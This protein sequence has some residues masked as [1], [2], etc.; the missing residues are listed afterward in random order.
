MCPGWV[1]LLS[2]RRHDLDDY[3]AA[4]LSL[5]LVS[6]PPPSFSKLGRF[7]RDE[8][9]AMQ[10]RLWL[11]GPSCL[12]IEIGG[13]CKTSRGTQRKANCEMQQQGAMIG[14]ACLCRTS[15]TCSSPCCGCWG[16]TGTREDSQS[17]RTGHQ[18]CL[19]DD[20]DNKCNTFILRLPGIHCGAD[21]ALRCKVEM[22]GLHALH[23]ELP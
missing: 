18:D 8:W 12:G 21:E 3:V 1:S 16:I 6:I 15:S 20:L 22:G 7:W 4:S 17:I 13:P 11:H 14:M 23:A 5:Y 2:L 9:I 10:M 19:K